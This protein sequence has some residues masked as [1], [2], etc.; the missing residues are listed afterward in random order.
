MK[1]AARVPAL[2]RRTSRSDLL[3]ADI[4]MSLDQ[5]SSPEAAVPQSRKFAQLAMMA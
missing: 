5:L 2:T 4:L 1:P 3:C